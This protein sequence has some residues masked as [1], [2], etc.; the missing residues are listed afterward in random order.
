[1]IAICFSGGETSLWEA[2]ITSGPPAKATETNSTTNTKDAKHWGTGLRL[3]G[4]IRTSWSSQRSEET[5]IVSRRQIHCNAAPIRRLA[6]LHIFFKYP[7]GYRGVHGHR[8]LGGEGR[9]GGT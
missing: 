8:R 7:C 1:M 4:D 5:R 6:V 2:R 3:A 9:A